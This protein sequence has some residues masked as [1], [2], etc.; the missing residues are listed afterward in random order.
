VC[1]EVNAARN[2]SFSCVRKKKWGTIF[3]WKTDLEGERDKRGANQAAPGGLK[4][5]V[6]EGTPSKEGVQKRVDS[7]A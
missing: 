5:K 6:R 1:Q 3:A 4:I 7:Y 2:I